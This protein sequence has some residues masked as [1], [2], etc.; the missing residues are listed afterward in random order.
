MNEFKDKAGRNLCPGDLI[1]YGHS[2][3]RCAGLQ[4][5]KVLAIT[6]GLCG[7]FLGTRVPKI[8]IIGVAAD[9]GYEQ[10]PE[11]LSKE[12]LLEFS[13]RVIR[14]TEDQIP[15]TILNLL[16]GYTSKKK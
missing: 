14:I 2:L 6:E 5:G 3:G 15:L 4:Y 9:Y 1:V 8:R 7:D 13:D 10:A 16:K 11:L 12:S